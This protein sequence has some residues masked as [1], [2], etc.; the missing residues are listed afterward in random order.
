MLH[1]MLLAAAMFASAVTSASA[2]NL[3][4]NGG[5]ETGDFT[6][7][8]TGTALVTVAQA[9]QIA[10]LDPYS[11]TY[12]AANTFAGG[13]NAEI[14]QQTITD[15]PGE[16]Y[17]ISIAVTSSGTP[18]GCVHCEAFA[19]RWNGNF[20]YGLAGSGPFSWSLLS[21]R[22]MIGTGTDVLSIDGS[23]QGG[24]AWGYDDIGVLG[25]SPESVPAPI[26]RAGLPGL[27]LAGVGLLGWW[28]RRKKI[29]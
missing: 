8:T 21:G 2:D 3:V 28:R 9:G 4:V 29:A 1:K 24:G 17:V 25:L 14:L 20:V 22:T 7:W 12:F 11:G 19:V 13:S 18:N 16:L 26:A 6:G 10:G 27:I 23:N 15:V 5:F